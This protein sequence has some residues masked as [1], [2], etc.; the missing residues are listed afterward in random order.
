MKP[1]TRES[2]Q[3]VVDRKR[4]KVDTSAWT[5]G[6]E[7]YLWVQ[8]LSAAERDQLEIENVRANTGKGKRDKIGFR[9]RIAIASC[10]DDEGN[11]V[12]RREDAALLA[13]K[14]SSVIESISEAYRRVNSM[15]QEDFDSMEALE[16][17]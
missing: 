14:P 7:S 15:T 9:T 12:F 4:E 8:E 3:Q 5:P 1:F 13:E 17:N 10:V 2:L 11:R 16:K 6:E